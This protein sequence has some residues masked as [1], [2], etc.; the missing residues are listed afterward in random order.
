[1]A[2]QAGEGAVFTFGPDPRLRPQAAPIVATFTV[3]SYDPA[4]FTLYSYA[5]VQTWAQAVKQAGSL[6]SADVIGALHKG[7]F[8]TVI[9]TIGFNEKGDVTGIA[10][11]SWYVV[12]GDGWAPVK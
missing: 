5:A 10:N 8:D 3:D 12:G 4:G 1:V 11:F 9:G 6:K 7:K 2:G